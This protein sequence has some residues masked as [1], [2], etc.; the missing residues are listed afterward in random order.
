M[1]RDE[2]ERYTPDI[3][4]SEGIVPVWLIVVYLSL[5]I[6]GIYYLIKYWGGP[7]T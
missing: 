4:S 2:K 1:E 6:W 5:L 3:E 7:G